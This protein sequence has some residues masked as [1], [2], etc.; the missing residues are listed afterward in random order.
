MENWMKACRAARFA[1][2]ESQVVFFA[3]VTR[4]RAKGFWM[5]LAAGY[6]SAAA[7]GGWNMEFELKSNPP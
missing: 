7:D 5:S 4:L 3:I 6:Y 1:A 2:G